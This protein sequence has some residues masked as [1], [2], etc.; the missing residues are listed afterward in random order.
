MPKRQHIRVQVP[1]PRPVSPAHVVA[2]LQTFEP[3]LDNHHYIIDYHPK[4]W[5]ISR[6]DLAVINGDPFFRQDRC[7]DDGL[8][9]SSSLHHDADD[10]DRRWWV[11]DVW[12]DVYWVPYLVPYFSRLK[13]YLAIGCRTEGGIRFRQCVSGGVVTRGSFTVV[14]RA[15][16]RAYGSGASPGRAR[17]GDIWDGDTEKGSIAGDDEGGEGAGSEGEGGNGDEHDLREKRASSW[18]ARSDVDTD[19]ETESE[20]AWEIVCECE[21]EIPLISV[22]SQYLHR[23]ANRRLCKHLCKSVIGATLTEFDEYRIYTANLYST[24]SL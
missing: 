11:C 16:G 21:I 19:A 13:R 1:I 3:L 20:P 24:L 12:E 10:D 18:D 5:P 15:T 14:E 22:L 8:V 7:G 9:A 23:G 2:T 4:P 6:R 17:G